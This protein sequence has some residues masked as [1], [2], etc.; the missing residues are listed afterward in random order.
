MEGRRVVV[1]GGTGLIGSRLIQAFL[2]EGRK[3]TLLTRH[4]D[5][6]LFPIGVEPR[7]WDDLTQVVDGA[8]GVFN[9]AGENIAAQRWTA[10]RKAALLHSRVDTTERISEALHWAKHK[11]NYFVNASAV[12]IYGGLDGRP[13]D[14]ATPAGK[15]FLADLCRKWEAA[16]E[17]AARHGVRLVQARLGVVLAPEGGALAKMMLPMKLY[18]GA[19]LGSGQQGLSWIHIEDLVTLLLE[20]GANPA[21]EGPINATAPFPV[22]N[23][24]F[25]RVLAKAMHRPVWPIP[26]CLTRT[27][28]RL[29]LG[30]M[31]DEMLLQ[32]AFVYPKKAQALGF[33]FKFPTLQEALADLIPGG[34]K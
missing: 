7:H 34:L 20:A 29:L 21:W 23:D 19:S 25:T 14:E 33:Q 9:L 11:P 17:P 15:G 8:E 3:V 5:R 16:A 22:S 13:V 12:G 24:H 2:A 28:L 4:P 27:A 6:T 31:A 26:A 32:G 30:E 1:A 10:H 18:Q